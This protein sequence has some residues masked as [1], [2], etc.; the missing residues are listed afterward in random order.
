MCG[1]VGSRS[2]VEE[3]QGDG[4]VDDDE[5][6]SEPVPSLTEALRAFESKPKRR[7]YTWKA[8]GDWRRHQLDYILVKHRFRNSVKD[9]KT[10]PGADIDSDHNLLV[11]KFRTR[12]KKITRFQKCR[13]RLNFEKLYA[14]RQSVQETLEEKL[15]ATE[16]ES[17]NAEVQWNNIKEC[18][19]DT[20]SDLVGKV[21]KIARK[22]WVTQE[23]MSKME[24]RRKW[25]NVNNEEGRRKYRRLRN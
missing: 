25:K 19:L 14:Q 13:P 20:I 24:E 15:S 8:P 7:I 1:A 23:M 10:L 2:C 9:V 17:R 11:A 22:P 3:G 6:K 12:L 4:G 18:M 5:A 21:E 16:G